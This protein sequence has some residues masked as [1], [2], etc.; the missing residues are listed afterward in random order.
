MAISDAFVH[1][2]TFNCAWP[3]FVLIGDPRTLCL[4]VVETGYTRFGT[5]ETG[6]VWLWVC[7]CALVVMVRVACLV[8]NI[9]SMQRGLGPV[10]LSISTDRTFVFYDIKL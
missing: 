3:I 1:V 4:V 7:F 10:D 8:F 2:K 5:C 9:A 6:L